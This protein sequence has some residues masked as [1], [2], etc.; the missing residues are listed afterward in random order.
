MAHH[1]EGCG[2]SI[3]P[4]DEVNVMTRD[5]GERHDTTFA[6][7]GHEQPYIARGYAVSDRGVM[8]DLEKQ[9]N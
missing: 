1:C 8:G 5:E 3:D 2:M 4:A 7:P 6:H 9:E